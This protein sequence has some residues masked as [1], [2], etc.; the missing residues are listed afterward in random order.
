MKYKLFGGNLINL[1]FAEYLIKNKKD[2]LWYT[3]GEKVGGHFSGLN[4]GGQFVDV[5]M[6]LLELGNNTI[7][8]HDGAKDVKNSRAVEEY[9]GNYKT[10]PAIIKCRMDGKLYP[11]HIIADDC[12]LMWERRYT[13]DLLA[14][15]PQEKWLN[16]YFEHTTYHEYCSLAYGNFYSD[17]LEK[18]ASKISYGGYKNLSARYHRT[19]WLPLYYPN[20]VAGENKVIETY[21]FRRFVQKSVAEVIVEKYNSILKNN[22]RYINDSE[23]N[24]QNLILDSESQSKLF[25]SCE[26]GKHGLQYSELVNKCTFQSKINFAIFSL[27]T[28]RDVGVDCINDVEDSEIYRISFQ[29]LSSGNRFI[30]VEGAGTFTE[31]HSWSRRVQSYLNDHLSLNDVVLEFAKCYI[32]GAKL[33]MPGAEAELGRIKQSIDQKYLEYDC[34]TYGLQNGF[35]ALS[36]NQQICHAINEWGSKS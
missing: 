1:V 6:V 31:D 25:I 19:A 26:I 23:L 12:K 4:L 33:P 11:D 29:T 5:G 9:F 20:T 15:S 30:F 22:K 14:E 18:F 8:S 10:A 28:D 35:Q 17:M 2:F 16:N 32:N 7:S 3:L 21:P 36:M 34:F 24:L 13:A 27:N